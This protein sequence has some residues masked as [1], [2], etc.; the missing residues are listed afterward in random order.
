VRQ[1]KVELETLN[2]EKRKLEIEKQQLLSEQNR[3]TEEWKLRFR[4]MTAKNDEI[5]SNLAEANQQYLRQVS[6][7]ERLTN[8]ILLLQDE[9]KSFLERYKQLEQKLIDS[10]NLVEEQKIKLL[11]E[12]QKANDPSQSPGLKDSESRGPIND[13]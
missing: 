4:E 2:E 13:S 9:H 1:F 8:Q 11:E 3:E 5:T 7:N 10:E 12:S 6:D